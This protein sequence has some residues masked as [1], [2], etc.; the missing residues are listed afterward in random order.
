MRTKNGTQTVPITTPKLLK[1]CSVGMLVIPNT[2]V[3]NVKGK[4]KMETLDKSALNNWR[5]LKYSQASIA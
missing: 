2:E 3:T 1:K 4:K 5:N